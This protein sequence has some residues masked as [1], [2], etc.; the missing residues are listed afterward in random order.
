MPATGCHAHNPHANF[1]GAGSMKEADPGQARANLRRR[2]G[3]VNV[4]C[5]G[6]RGGPLR[7]ELERSTGSISQQSDPGSS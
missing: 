7:P 5:D 3:C 1:L 4:S 2:A 6:Q